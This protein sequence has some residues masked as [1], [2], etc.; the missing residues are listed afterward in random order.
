MRS[1]SGGVGRRI[2]VDRLGFWIACSSVTT[3][4]TALLGRPHYSPVLGEVV[5]DLV[6]AAVAVAT[7]LVS[8]LFM[9]LLRFLSP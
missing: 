2:Q 7:A 4:S 9:L 5:F 6:G 8:W 1:Q 3:R